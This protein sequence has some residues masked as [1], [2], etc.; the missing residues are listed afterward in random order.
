MRKVFPAKLEQTRLMLPT[1]HPI[2]SRRA[3]FIDLF[4]QT[5][6]GLFLLVRYTGTAATLHI[7]TKFSGPYNRGHRQEEA[8]LRQCSGEEF[9]HSGF[10]KFHLPF[11]STLSKI[12]TF[13]YN[14]AILFI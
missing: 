1:P 5:S 7:F 2:Q 14:S 6:M 3:M 12:T 4:E 13:N 9:P 11:G 8:W 10:K